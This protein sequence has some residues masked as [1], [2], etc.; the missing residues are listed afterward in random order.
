MTLASINILSILLFIV[1]LGLLVAIHEFG[2]FIMAKTFNV[3][4]NEF[5]IGFGP[6][7][8]HK[9][10]GETTYSLR[11][12]P[13][14]GYVSM[15]GEGVEIEDGSVPKSR[16]LLGIKKWKRAIIMSAGIILNFVLGFILFFIN[17]AFFAQPYVT[18][19]I[20]VQEESVAASMGLITGDYIIKI[21][22]TAFI[23]GNQKETIVTSDIDSD[24]PAKLWNEALAYVVEGENGY[25]FTPLTENDTMTLIITYV[26]EGSNTSD[27]KD[28]TITLNAVIN[29]DQ[30]TFGWSKMGISTFYEY[31]R[32]ETMG[33]ILK[34]TNQEF[35]DNTTLIAKTLGGLFVGKNWNEIGGP[36][37]ILTQSGEVLNNYGFGMYIYLWGAI[38]VN[39]A[40]FNLLPFPG[41]D[42][43][44]LLVVIIEGIFRKEIPEKVKNIVSTI[45]MILLFGLMIFVTCKDIIGLF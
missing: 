12:I 19:Q 9:K 18:N 41:L 14:G 23:D 5:S 16:S 10:K 33:D 28:V 13:L 44:H 7:L 35:A 32:Y 20:T 17:N 21:E 37:S 25:D 4:V 3:Y 31:R 45:G 27:A 38:S 22:K 40:I 29:E 15:F 42:G 43:W 2:H 26:S 39:L 24:N 8:L 34:S 1:S 11:A 6:Q 30:K 36:V